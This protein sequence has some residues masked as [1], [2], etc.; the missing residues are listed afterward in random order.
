M[1]LDK[2]KMTEFL[3]LPA[4]EAKAIIATLKQAEK[5]ND[6]E[7]LKWGARRIVW[8]DDASEIGS[9]DD[10]FYPE[11]LFNIAW[12]KE[13]ESDPPPESISTT[14]AKIGQ[15]KPEAV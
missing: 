3:M 5:T 9:G 2:I 12:A 6:I 13:I 10:E 7:A 4:D 15:D 11:R 14:I 1:K 8:L